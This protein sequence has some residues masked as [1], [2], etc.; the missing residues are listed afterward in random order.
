MVFV[1][2]YAALVSLVVITFVSI[3]I[4][5]THGM[6][7]AATF[8]TPEESER[9]EQVWREFQADLA[10]RSSNGKQIIAEKSGH[11][12]QFYQPELVIDAIRQVLEATRR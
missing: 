12:I 9:M 7:E 4:V 6:K 2:V 1:Y 10:R 8:S 5:L 3:L 11:Y